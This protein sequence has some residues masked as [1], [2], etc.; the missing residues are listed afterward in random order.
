MDFFGDEAFTQPGGAGGQNRTVGCLVRVCNSAYAPHDGGRHE[1]PPVPA[2]ERPGL[3]LSGAGG[4]LARRLATKICSQQ[5]P[6]K[7]KQ[8]RRV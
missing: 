2:L 1:A 6:R 3:S 4:G 8:R 7:R 5:H